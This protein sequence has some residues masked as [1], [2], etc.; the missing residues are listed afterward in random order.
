[1]ADLVGLAG[2]SLGGSQEGQI[3]P[4]RLGIYGLSNTSLG[5]VIDFSVAPGTDRNY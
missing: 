3:V 4:A 5:C 1:M 2:G